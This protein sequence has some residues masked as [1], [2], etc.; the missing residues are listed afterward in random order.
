MTQL[1]VTVNVLMFPLV[2]T[3]SAGSNLLVPSTEWHL[4]GP[5]VFMNIKA[6][7]A[8]FTYKTLKKNHGAQVL[9]VDI[10]P[11]GLFCVDFHKLDFKNI[12]D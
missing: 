12:V 7:Q 2:S 3:H 8:T 11:C 6:G 1:A 10:L 5:E 4:Q 9:H